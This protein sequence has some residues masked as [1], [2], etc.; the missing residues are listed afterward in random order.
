MSEREL[1]FIVARENAISVEAALAWSFLEDSEH[2]YNYVNSLYFDTDNF[3]FAMDKASSDYNKSKV[4][5][6]WYTSKR[7]DVADK[8]FLEVKNKVGS[9]RNKSR[10]ELNLDSN[11]FFDAVHSGTFNTLLR[12]HLCK[13][14]PALLRLDLKPQFIVSYKRNRY[15][16]KFSRSRIALDTDISSQ[17]FKMNRQYIKSSTVLPN[18]VLEVKGN[19]NSLPYSLRHITKRNISKFAF[20][21]YFLCFVDLTGYSQ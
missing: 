1:K 13:N 9:T 20:S 8:C 14:A 6:R 4:R 17:V 5:V 18:S 15:F 7:G 3:D 16:D 21:K 10:Q 2:P 11:S 12:D 19:K